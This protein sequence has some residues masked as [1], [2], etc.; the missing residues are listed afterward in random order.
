MSL[1]DRLNSWCHSR[2]KCSCW[3]DGDWGECCEMHDKL[4]YNPK[5]HSRAWVDRAFRKCIA[6]RNKAMAWIMWFG[7]RC[8]GWIW[9]NKFRAK[10]GK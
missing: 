3:F 5:T 4:Y 1:M 9:W 2:A 10:E 7:V 8:F 6:R